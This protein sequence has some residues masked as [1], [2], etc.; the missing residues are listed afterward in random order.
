MPHGKADGVRSGFSFGI[1]ETNV[2]Q[3][4]HLVSND[5]KSLSTKMKFKKVVRLS[6]QHQNCSNAAHRFQLASIS[7]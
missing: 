3:G 4:N 6:V 5:S 2:L 1:E 7:Y